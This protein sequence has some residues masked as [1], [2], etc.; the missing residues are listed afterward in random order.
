MKRRFGTILMLCGAVLVGLALSLFLYNTWDAN[1]AAEAS[2]EVL[3]TI[4]DD[5]DDTDESEYLLM[6][7]PN[8]EMTVVNIDGYDYIGYLSIP[9]INLRL[10]VMS[11]WS[12]DGLKIAPGRFSGSVY[13]DDMVIAGHNYAKHFSPIKWLD[14]GTEVYFIDM[15]NQVWTY[16]LIQIETLT[17]TQVEEMAVKS[18]DDDWDMTLFT[19]TTGGQAR[20]AVRLM[21]VSP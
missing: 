6:M 7:D 17:P 10:P 1:R 2:A 18:E 20:C 13:T 8:R 16:Q 5:L 3:D 15:E 14:Y 12:Y 19:C 9:S 11:E 21:R 4:D